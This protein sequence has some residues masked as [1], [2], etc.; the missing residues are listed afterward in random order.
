[1]VGM[2]V[3]R[4]SFVFAAAAGCLLLACV[5]GFVGFIGVTALAGS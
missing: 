4:R 3:H 1:M 5:I 2:R